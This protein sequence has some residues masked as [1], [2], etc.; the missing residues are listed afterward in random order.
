MFQQF[1]NRYLSSRL[2]NKFRKHIIQNTIYNLDFFSRFFAK[3]DIF[4]RKVGNMGVSQSCIKFK[5]FRSRSAHHNDL[6]EKIKIKFT[7]ISELDLSFQ[8]TLI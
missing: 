4:L 2:V 5:K 8:F 7:G 6:R 3:F 1:Y